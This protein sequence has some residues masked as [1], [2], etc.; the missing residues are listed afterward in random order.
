MNARFPHLRSLSDRSIANLFLLPT[1]LL[2]VGMNIFPLIW[3]LGLSFC[4]YSSIGNAPPKWIGG[5]NYTDLLT[6]PAINQRF[7]VTAEFTLLAVGAQLAIGFGL[8]LLLN[9]AFRLK[10]IVTTLLLLPMMLSPAIVG[11]FW[12]FMFDASNGLINY[13]LQSAHLQD[14]AHPMNWLGGYPSALYALA[15]TDTWMWSP[16]VM[17]ISLAGLS[18]V[19]PHLYEAAEVDRASGW[20]K[21]RYITLPMV[22]PLLMVALLFRTMDCFKLFDLVFVMTSGGP[23]AATETVSYKL[24]W[25]AFPQHHTGLACALA[26]II[27]LVII[28]LTN[29]YMKLLARVRGDGIP[30]ASP[31]A[32]AIAEKTQSLPVLGWLLSSPTRYLL[33]LAVVAFWPYTRL[34][35]GFLTAHVSALLILALLV[36]AAYAFSRLP[37]PLRLPLALACLAFGFVGGFPAPAGVRPWLWLIAAAAL[38]WL[39]A[40]APQI[41]RNVLAY[42]VV[43]AA[44]A[45]TLLPVYWI[46]ITSF[47]TPVDINALTPKFAFKPTLENYD[48]LFYQHEGDQITGKVLGLNAFPH[49]LGNSLVIGI[50]STLLAVAMGTMAAYALAR[51]RIKAKGDALFFI[52]ST[53][54]LPAIAV[55]IP[56][57]LMYTRLGLLGTHLGLILL[58]TVFNLSFS[59]YL[60][61]GF[62]DE[63]P[64]EYDDA[65]LLDGYSRFAAFRKISL[66]LAMTGVAA[67]AVF[68]FITAWN[69]FAFAQILSP[70]Q[71]LTAPPSINAL[72]GAGGMDWGQVAAGSFLFLLPAAIFTFLMRKHLL[73]GVTFGAI[74]R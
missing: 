42:A 22:A 25:L 19:P 5:Q 24:Y 47:K 12:R 64:H 37:L 15:I 32:S 73:R 26:Y 44:L 28:G 31:L 69:E 55:V 61:K 7:T 4:D 2:L 10:G 9:R 51:F 20:F 16:F 18:A 33:L 71:P 8:A 6:D 43:A 40:R 54:M 72:T 38:V 11:L 39:V 13:L 1:I 74:K 53:R 45:I 29:L 50:L 3:S 59:T 63:V 62:F 48:R 30:D 17:L 46:A 70:L 60:M 14:P 35:G 52:L 34:L 27:L 67:T 36:A 56:I 58:Y 49:Q 41:V 68:C 57:Y 66:P 21:F 65:A 23:G